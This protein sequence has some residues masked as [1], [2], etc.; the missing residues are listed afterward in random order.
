M[1]VSEPWIARNTKKEK[2]PGQRISSPTLLSL[3]K[4]QYCAKCMQFIQK[5]ETNFGEYNQYD[6]PKF[7]AAFVK[8]KSHSSR[9]SHRELLL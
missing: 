1:L 8:R 2:T 6:F 9:F 4:R 3:K 5:R 7:V